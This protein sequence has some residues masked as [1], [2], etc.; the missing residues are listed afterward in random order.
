MRPLITSGRS[1]HYWRADSCG[2]NALNPT[3]IGWKTR[4]L[5]LGEGVQYAKNGRFFSKSHRPSQIGV[6]ARQKYLAATVTSATTNC[7]GLGRSYVRRGPRS[8]HPPYMLKFPPCEDPRM[9]ETCKFSLS[10]CSLKNAKMP[11]CGTNCSSVVLLVCSFLGGC[12][13]ISYCDASR[14][15]K[16]GF[17]EQEAQLRRREHAT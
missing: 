11:F 17:Y 8:G 10:R 13:R 9:G 16:P 3:Q 7:A 4:A 2:F 1:R 5:P 15:L 6:L 12:L 14:I